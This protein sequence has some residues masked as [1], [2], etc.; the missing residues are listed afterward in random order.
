MGFIHVQL[1]VNNPTLHD[2]T[3]LGMFRQ[4]VVWLHYEG[5]GIL[6]KEAS[7]TLKTQRRTA[8]PATCCA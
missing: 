6:Q 2:S 5:E 1:T 7:T 4:K 3:V 8:W